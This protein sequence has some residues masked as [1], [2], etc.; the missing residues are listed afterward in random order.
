MAASIILT[1]RQHGCSYYGN[2]AERFRRWAEFLFDM[3]HAHPER[4]QAFQLD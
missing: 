2:S 1:L 3:A 4:R